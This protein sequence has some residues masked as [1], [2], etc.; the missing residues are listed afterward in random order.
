MPSKPAKLLAVE[1]IMSLV[2]AEFTKPSF[3]V[4][5]GHP[6]K[7]RTATLGS[8]DRR[9]ETRGYKLENVPFRNSEINCRALSWR[10]VPRS[11][12]GTT[13]SRLRPGMRFDRTAGLMYSGSYC[14]PKAKEHPETSSKYFSYN[15]RHVTK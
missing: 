10:F 12:I 14:L 11:D 5:L 15:V 2:K 1:E 3:K 13:C 7:S 6:S 4:K 9:V 8:R